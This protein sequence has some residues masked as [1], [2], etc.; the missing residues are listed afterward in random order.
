MDHDCATEQST[1]IHTKKKY[2][3]P[4]LT[5]PRQSGTLRQRNS[6]ASEN[7]RQ[8]VKAS[9]PIAQSVLQVLE[10]GGVVG[11]RPVRRV[12]RPDGVQ[13][14]EGVAGGEELANVHHLVHAVVGQC[15]AV[16]WRLAGRLSVGEE[17]E[18]EEVKTFCKSKKVQ[19]TRR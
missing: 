8:D 12:Y 13:Y 7:I 2:S 10:E 16:G 9:R 5:S 6:V 18:E 17:E 1:S 14:R 15:L 3:S 11:G 19:L 4:H